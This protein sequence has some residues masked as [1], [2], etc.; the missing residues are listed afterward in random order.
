LSSSR[1]KLENVLGS[2][3]ASEINLRM[4]EVVYNA[5]RENESLDTVA[6]GGISSEVGLS[7]VGLLCP[8][9]MTEM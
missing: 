1:Y 5:E 3:D 7:Q 8:L 6:R 4:L 2:D 9:L